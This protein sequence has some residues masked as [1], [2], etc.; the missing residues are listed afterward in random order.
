MVCSGDALGANA[1]PANTTARTLGAKAAG[2]GPKRITSKKINGRAVSN[3]TIALAP[4]AAVQ[5]I[6]AVKGAQNLF[7]KPASNGLAFTVVKGTDDQFTKGDDGIYMVQTKGNNAQ[8]SEVVFEVKN[9]T[10]E[11]IKT[12]IKVEVE[13]FGD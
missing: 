12:S 1:G 11:Q 10:A 6:I 8:R 2:S 4:G 13:D 5:F 3:Q 7:I 9:E